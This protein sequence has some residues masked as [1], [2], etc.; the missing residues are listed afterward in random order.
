MVVSPIVGDEEGG[1]DSMGYEEPKE[2]RPSRGGG[3]K[4]RV[5][6]NTGLFHEE[7]VKNVPRFP[8]T[9]H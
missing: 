6:P 8:P 3:G 5:T 7:K 4:V 1:R 9:S 2:S